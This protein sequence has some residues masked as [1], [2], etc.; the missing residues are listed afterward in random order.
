ME[1][2][3]SVPESDSCFSRNGF[4]SINSGGGVHDTKL[5]IP[6][7]NIGVWKNTTVQ[8]PPGLRCSHC[9]LRFT[10]RNGNNWGG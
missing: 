8:L 6:E 2:C 5:M 7:N 3:D 9:V 1:I 10:Y 4:L